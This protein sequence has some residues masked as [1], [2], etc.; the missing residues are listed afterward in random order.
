M[1]ES[2]TRL[3]VRRMNEAVFERLMMEPAE[4]TKNRNDARHVCYLYGC[5]QRTFKSDLL[6]HDVAVQ[7]RRVV[8]EQAVTCLMNEVIYPG[9]P[10]PSHAQ[11]LQIIVMDERSSCIADFLRE[12][13]VI[14]DQRYKGGG[15]EVTLK[16][17]IK[18]SLTAIA[19]AVTDEGIMSP[20][21]HRLFSLARLFMQNEPLAE[22]MLAAQPIHQP[23]SARPQAFE[24]MQAIAELES[25]LLGALFKLS[26]LGVEG[27]QTGWGIFER[28]MTATLQDVA[29]EEQNLWLPAR[30]VQNDLFEMIDQL[31]R[32][33]PAIR[34]QVIEWVGYALDLCSSRSKL[35]LKVGQ[36]SHGFAMNLTAVLLRLAQP[37]CK[38][39]D[40]EKVLKADF[41]YGAWTY[42]GVK[43]RLRGL[44]NDTTLLPKKPIDKLTKQVNFPTECF[45]AAHKAL[46]IS[47][48]VLHDRL[49]ELN[50]EMGRMRTIYED[51]RGQVIDLQGQDF[52]ERLEQQLNACMSWYQSMRTTL[53]E[54]DFFKML[55]NF[56]VASAHW[57]VE[58]ATR[59]GE[60][61]EQ[62]TPAERLSLVPE[63]I[64]ENVS[65]SVVMTRRFGERN[66]SQ[67]TPHLAPLLRLITTF[68]GSADRVNNPHLRAK[69]AEMLESLVITV[70]THDPHGINS[71]ISNGDVCALLETSIS[72]PLA[73]TLIQVFVSIEMTGQSVSFE[74]KFQYRRPMYLVLEQLW[75]LKKHRGHME[76][77]SEEAVLHIEDTNQPLFL[78]F[79]NLLI[80]DANFLVDESFQ[81]MQRLKAL[82]RE[83]ASW[84]TL[85]IDRRQQNEG[86]F[87]HQGMIARFHNV[88][89]RDTIRT[90]TWLTSS[91]VVRRLF[92]HPVLIDRIVVMLNFF[93]LHLVGPDQ[94][95]L[96]VQNLQDY[97]FKPALLVESIAQT[98][99]HLAGVKYADDAQDSRFEQDASTKSFYEALVRDERSYKPELFVEAQKVLNRI[100]RG[101]L[102]VEIEELGRKVT[103]AQNAITRQE[104]LT[105]DAPEEFMDPLIFTL[106]TDPVILPSSGVTVDRNTI[107]RHLLS[108]QTDPFN[109]QPLN[110]EQVKPNEELKVRIDK[111]LREIRK[112]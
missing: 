91:P 25:S 93:L 81:F 11:Q 102:G 42:D 84:Q 14:V 61:F 29:I 106:M 2:N 75:K 22:A 10:Q 99:L 41:S 56:T 9:P 23:R 74:E 48:R 110:L 18:P 7:V 100:G 73:E 47:T 77:L 4:L 57:L 49:M 68:M 54:P 72:D 5:Y 53:F 52:V 21:Q 59:D 32:I 6:P 60:P 1:A 50:K 66:L 109:R 30:R 94:K 101:V 43:I 26:Y 39:R 55:V 111:W 76:Q 71:S 82:E 108:D 45:F 17:I 51:S 19:Q 98:Y 35:G 3:T 69:L 88:M 90:L 44:E 27:G 112:K 13:S 67:F 87:R 28:M 12:L 38:V 16:D 36:V 85:P 105:Q 40:P 96:R 63:H 92:L 34:A 58:V 80:N 46:L 37:F 15:E 95:N 79:A 8:L 89:A 86:N 64:L 97:E 83:R 78:R 70:N 103:E 31:L 24:E 104:E 62:V 65:D 107:A 33:S 20:Q